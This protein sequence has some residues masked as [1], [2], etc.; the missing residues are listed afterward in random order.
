MKRKMLSKREKYKLYNLKR[1]EVP[2]SGVDLSPVFNEINRL[3]DGIKGVLDSGQDLTQLNFQ[4]V[5]SN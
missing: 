3:R 5:K 4:F 1:K 2:K